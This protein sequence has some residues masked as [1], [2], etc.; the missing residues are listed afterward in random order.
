M[1][2]STLADAICDLGI[3]GGTPI[4]AVPLNNGS[5]RAPPI[6]GQYDDYGGFENLHSEDKAIADLWLQG[7]N[8]DLVEKGV[9]DNTVHD[10]A[11]R[12]NMNFEALS[13]A[14]PLQVYRDCENFWHPDK[15]STITKQVPANV[16]TLNNVEVL[17]GDLIHQLHIDSP[18]QGMVRI[19]G[20]NYN[21][22]QLSVAQEKLNSVFATVI[23]NQSINSFENELL[24]FSKPQ[25]AES[26]YE[27]MVCWN[28]ADLTSAI[29]KYYVD[30][31]FVRQDVWD[32]LLAEKVP[33]E[34]DIGGSSL[35]STV[36]SL[37][38][39]YQAVKEEIA[40]KTEDMKTSGKTLHFKH[41][42]MDKL[43]INHGYLFEHDVGVIGLETHFLLMAL[44]S[45][46]EEEKLHIVTKI[47]ELLHINW[48]LYVSRRYWRESNRIGYQD[49]N[50]GGQLKYYKIITS[51]AN[52]KHKEVSLRRKE[53]A[54]LFKEWD[55]KNNVKQ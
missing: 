48:W 2:H 23:T 19:R 6:R 9:G 39:L 17:L 20:K 42:W 36:N 16:A 37:Y 11:V 43:N 33:D 45:I 18:L 41:I 24:V 54:R 55:K 30:W 8:V 47:A 15:T 14:F 25:P 52:T 4:V 1:G 35:Q 34:D 29:T 5:L 50:W 27:G 26:R 46:P 7:F 51:I 12:K 3:T 22:S 40:N 53:Q 21:N 38:N 10:I 28:A 44:S 49:G 32:A 31:A 13:R